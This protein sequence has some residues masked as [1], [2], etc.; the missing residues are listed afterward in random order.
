MVDRLADVIQSMEFQNL[1]ESRYSLGIGKS[2][3]IVA[4]EIRHR[5]KALLDIK[6]A[7]STI[8][9]LSKTVSATAG[10]PVP[11]SELAQSFL[12]ERFLPP[13]LDLSQQI[14]DAQ[15]RFFQ[16]NPDWGR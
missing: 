6:P 10:I 16:Q 15:A 1:S 11:N 4:S 7:K 13:A 5:M 3:Q 9:F 2:I 12:T 14:A 8:D